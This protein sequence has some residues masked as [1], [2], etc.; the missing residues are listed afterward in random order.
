M[1]DISVVCKTT[2]WTL[3]LLPYWLDQPHFFL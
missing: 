1:L 2:L 3:Q